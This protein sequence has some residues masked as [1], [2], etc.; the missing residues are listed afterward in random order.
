MRVRSQI[1]S[2]AGER[3]PNLREAQS[4][5]CEERRVFGPLSLAH[6]FVFRVVRVQREG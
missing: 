3:E 1:N 4:A 2:R 6:G 5:E